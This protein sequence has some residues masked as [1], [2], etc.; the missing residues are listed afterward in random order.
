MSHRI[1]FWGT[2]TISV[3][4]FEKLLTLSDVE[5]VGVVT[6]PDSPQGRHQ[7]LVA[8]PLKQAALL[9]NIPVLDPEKLKDPAVLSAIQNLKPDISVVF[10]FGRII[11]QALLDVAPKGTVNVHPSLLP[12]YRGPSPIQAAILNGDEET[13][14]SLMVLDADMDHGP[15]LAQEKIVLTQTETLTS[16]SETISHVAAHLL[17]KY[18]SQYLSSSLTPVPQ[19]HEQATLCKMIEREDGK[20]DWSTSAE[21][22]ERMSRAFDPW[23]GIWTEWTDKNTK[24]RTKLFSVTVTD[25]VLQPG[26]LQSADGNLLIGTGTTAIMCETVQV[27]G[28]KCL[29][30]EELERGMPEFLQGRFV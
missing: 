23:P 25:K 24:L 9:H 22:I 18:L 28:K 11:P 16:L 15:I 12:K 7:E 13:G 29:P 1:L 4:T 19:D 21:N 20:I 10:A 27:E 2:A 30:L 14:V 3:P 17:E 8:S 6:R 26:E 5:V